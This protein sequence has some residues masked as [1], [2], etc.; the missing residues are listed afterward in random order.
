MRYTNSKGQAYCESDTARVCHCEHY[1]RAGKNDC[2]CSIYI[3][4][5]A[6]VPP[7][8]LRVRAKAPPEGVRASERSFACDAVLAAARTGE[9]R[10]EASFETALPRRCEVDR[11]GGPV[12][13]TDSSQGNA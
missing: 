11:K 12:P 10:K 13:V 7:G 6:F 3:F 2:V 1:L 5:P 4:P 8:R 9:K